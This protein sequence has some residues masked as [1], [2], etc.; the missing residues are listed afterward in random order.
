MTDFILAAFWL[1]LALMVLG[2]FA[3]TW[4]V[5]ALIADEIGRLHR[6][7]VHDARRL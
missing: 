7:R 1:I 4:Y 2:V 5:V 3:L 6:R